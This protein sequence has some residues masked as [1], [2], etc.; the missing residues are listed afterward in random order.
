MNVIEANGAR[1]PAIGLGTMTLKGRECIDTVKTA[2]E[3]GY[4]HVDTAERYGNE[5]WVG[6][7]LHQGLAASGLKREDVF[8]VTKVYWDKLAP[9]DFETSVAQSLQKLKLPWVDLLLIHWNNPKVPL[10]DSI[11]SLCNAKK[12]GQTRHVGVANFTTAMLDEATKLASEPLVTNQIE[13]H[14]FLDQT[15]VL[16]ACKKHGLSITG[17]CPLARGQVPG[18]ETLQ[19]IGKAHN[20]SSSQVAL[21]YLVQQGIIPIPRT[22]KPDH[23][24]ANLAVFDFT[25]S[26][27]EMSEI[28]GLRKPD[29]RVVNPAHAPQ[30][31]N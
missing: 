12:R 10:A 11:K 17:Y 29:G 15:K 5:E 20:K 6:E 16:A 2:L 9:G 7:G 25:L 28:A 19:R 18:N 27:A 1:I 31:D 4:R 22:A 23:L 14:P 3:L 24:A 26:A 30:W 13:T 21:R 8:V